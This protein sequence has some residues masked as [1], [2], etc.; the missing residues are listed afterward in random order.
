MSTAHMNGNFWNSL[1][2]CM[3]F[4]DWILI[5]YVF[6][7]NIMCHIIFEEKTELQDQYPLILNPVENADDPIQDHN[8]SIWPLTRSIITQIVYY[9]VFTCGVLKT[10][11]LYVNSRDWLRAISQSIA[12]S[13]AEVKTLSSPPEVRTKRKRPKCLFTTFYVKIR[14]PN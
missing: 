9:R 2:T 11:A 8:R 1:L 3:R 12:V 6:I 13:G 14:S 7:M 4:R 5:M 10:S